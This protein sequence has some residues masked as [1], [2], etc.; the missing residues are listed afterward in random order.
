MCW[1]M[2]RLDSFFRKS[3]PTEVTDSKDGQLLVGD[4]NSESKW[5]NYF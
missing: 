2:Y 4:P 3:T 5:I 1:K